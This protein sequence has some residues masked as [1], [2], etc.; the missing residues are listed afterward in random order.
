[1]EIVRTLTPS[2]RAGHDVLPEPLPSVAAIEAAYAGRV[3]A[4]GAKT[5]R[6]LL[7]FATSGNAALGSLEPVLAY[8]RCAVA[9]LQAA[10]DAGLVTMERGR[11]GWQHPLV[12]VRSV[13]RCARGRP[14]RSASRGRGST[15]GG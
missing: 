5:R 6:A 13:L 8:Q 2:Q 12:R 7:V 1:V 11:L 4:L 3:A 14:G 10:M 9:D 15:T